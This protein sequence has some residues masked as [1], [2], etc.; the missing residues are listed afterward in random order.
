MYTL[1]EASIKM[2]EPFRSVV[3]DDDEMALADNLLM[4]MRWR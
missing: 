1:N 4:T 2:E 3:G